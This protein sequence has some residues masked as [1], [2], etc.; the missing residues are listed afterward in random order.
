MCSE[1]KAVRK[2]QHPMRARQLEGFL[3]GA[4]PLLA[5]DLAKATAISLALLKNGMCRAQPSGE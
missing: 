3:E 1:A 4:S 5:D 2:L